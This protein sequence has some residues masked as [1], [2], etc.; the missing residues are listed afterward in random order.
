MHTL[1]D[2][3]NDERP[4]EAFQRCAKTPAE[5]RD[6]AVL[7]TPLRLRKWKLIFETCGFSRKCL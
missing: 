5:R 6:V 7:Y 3:R 4:C 2:A 1:Y